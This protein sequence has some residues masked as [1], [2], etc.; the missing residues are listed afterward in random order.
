MFFVKVEFWSNTARAKN[1]GGK[2]GIP[3]SRLYVDE[4]AHCLLDSLPI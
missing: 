1:N 3:G 4:D 2:T